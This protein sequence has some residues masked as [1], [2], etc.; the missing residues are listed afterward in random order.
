M[1]FSGM[2]TSMELDLEL[3]MLEGNVGSALL[4]PNYKQEII[5]FRI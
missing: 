3:T 1:L 2:E 4:N 5:G